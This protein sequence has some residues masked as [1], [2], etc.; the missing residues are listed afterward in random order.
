MAAICVLCRPR[1]QVRHVDG[2]VCVHLHDH[3]L[4]P[5][6][7]SARRVGPVR[8]RGNQADVPM[9]FSPVLVISPN[10]QQ[11]GILTLGTRVGLERHPVQAA[12]L[13]QPVLELRDH[14]SVTGSLI[15]GRERVQ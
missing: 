10:H 2:A 8:R 12:Y 4:H 3:D 11:P 6:H 5:S 9:G 15:R 7:H 13:R 1:L 14:D